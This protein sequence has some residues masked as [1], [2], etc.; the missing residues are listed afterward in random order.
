MVK[1]PVGMPDEVRKFAPK[2]R[3]PR[4][5][6]GNATD[7]AGEALVAMLQ[8]AASLSNDNCDRAL[9]Y[10][11]KLSGE[12]RAA[13][14]RIARLQAEHE[15]A[16]RSAEESIAAARAADDRIAQLQ[17]ELERAQRNAEERARQT[18]AAEER[19][20]QLQDELGRVLQRASRAEGWLQLIRSEIEEK[21][22]APLAAA[23][24][25]RRPLH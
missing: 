18:W 3:E 20:D 13:E 2:G 17:V 14:D 12:L 15:R 1:R 7:E 16:Q 25:E 21:L 10:S 24:A 5:E 19:I 11:Q 4:R 23:R 6:S 9:A 22:I 8:Q